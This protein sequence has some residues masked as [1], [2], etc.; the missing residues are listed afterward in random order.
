MV[1]IWKMGEK[2]Y[3]IIIIIIIIVKFLNLKLKKN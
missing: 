2:N 3:Y 1:P